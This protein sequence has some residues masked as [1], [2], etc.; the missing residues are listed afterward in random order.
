MKEYIKKSVP[1]TIEDRQKLIGQVADILKC[2]RE[3]GD[4][5]LKRYSKLFDGLEVSDFRVSD[6]EIQAAGESLPLDLRTCL[7]DVVKR[8]KAFAQAQKECL[9]DLEWEPSPGLFLGHRY[10]PVESVGA[11]IPG[12][13]YPTMSAP[14]MAII[15]AKVAGVPRIIAATPPS[16]NGKIHPA[17][18]YGM[19]L[20]G[21]DEIYAVGGAQAIAALTFG[22]ESIKAVDMVVGPGN[23]YVAEAKRQVFGIVGIDLIAGPSE[24]MVIADEHARPDWVAAD[25]LA[26]CEHDTQARGA[27]VTTSQRL[28]KDVAFEIEQQLS[29]LATEKVARASWENCGEIIL[30]DNLEEAA[31]AANEWAPEHLEVH[32]QEPKRLMPL[33][34]NYGSLFVGEEAAEVFADKLVGTNHILPTLKGARYTGGLSV[35]R[36]LKCITHQWCTP[37]VMQ[38]LIAPV[39]TQGTYEGMVAHAA[40]A[41]IRLS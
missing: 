13:R 33:L 34:R 1:R 28:A 40:A 22:T 11:Y 5:A 32:T 7:E 39:A 21:A 37:E 17:I 16:H 3:E 35:G 26:Q 8:V 9:L 20:S 2:V 23:Q 29:H 4:A 36:F 10:L 19:K 24:V 25:I 30:V 38:S 15:P 18:L 6:Q 41:T 12:G 14:M 31:E 27:L